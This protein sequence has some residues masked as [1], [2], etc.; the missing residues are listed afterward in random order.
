MLNNKLKK[1]IAFIICFC[2]ILFLI[3]SFSYIINN[4][5]HSCIGKD[6]SICLKLYILQDIIKS[7]TITAFYVNIFYFIINILRIFITDNNLKSKKSLCSLK[8]KLN[9]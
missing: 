4:A 7:I 6:C 9:N 2:I 3:F 1:I 8:V 5:E